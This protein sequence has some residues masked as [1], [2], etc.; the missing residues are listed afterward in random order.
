LQ[1]AYDTDINATWAVIDVERQ[2]FRADVERMRA[3]EK[4]LTSIISIVQSGIFA[5]TGREFNINSDA[6]LV[7]AFATLGLQ[8]QWF[9]DKEEYKTD[10]T[11]MKQLQKSTDEHMAKLAGL[12]LQY[13]QAEKILS[14]YITGVL[15]MVQED[16]KIH[17]DYWV[18]PDDWG[19][20]GTNTGRLSSSNPNLQNLKKKPLK[21]EDEED[22]AV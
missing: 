5:I 10:K 14:T 4:K 22:E 20:G 18:S 17:C 6:E 12:V 19:K 1:Q 21:I 8:W 7:N 16:G 15:P 3:D 9:T 13:R 2:G 11:V